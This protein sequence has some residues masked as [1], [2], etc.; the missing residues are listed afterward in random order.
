M[1]PFFHGGILINTHQRLERGKQTDNTDYPPEEP[2]YRTIKGILAAGTENAG[3]GKPTGDAS[4]AAFLHGPDWL[5]AIVVPLAAND[6]PA[7]VSVVTRDE[8][9]GDH[10]DDAPTRG[11]AG[12]GATS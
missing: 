2:R 5:F 1:V 11:P 9:S 7:L 8:E 3:A 6:D 12:M 10:G 4:A